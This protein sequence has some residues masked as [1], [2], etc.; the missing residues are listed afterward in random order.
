MKPSDIIIEVTEADFEQQVLAYSH[1]VPVVVD[2]WAEW[3][4]PCRVIGPILE[5]LAKEAAGSF[6]LAKLNVDQNSKLAMRYAVQSIPSVKTFK[7]GLVVSEFLGALPEQQIK[8][9]LREVIPNQADLL[10]EK[11]WSL[12]ALEKF[13]E[14][15]SVFR[16]VLEIEPSSA[17][18]ELGLVKNLLYQGRNQEALEILY[19]F[20][21]SREL[22][23]AEKLIP[24]TE[25]LVAQPAAPEIL[26]IDQDEAAYQTAI[27]LVKLG[28]IEAAM[29]GLLDV[30][31]SDKTFHE[32]EARQ[33]MIGLLELLG[34]QN[35][36]TRQY[37]NELASILF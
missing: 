10:L 19:Q 32:N 23:S 3:C 7:G 21:P 25:A 5:K 2:F 26:P 27:R 34:D 33:V 1:L 12:V 18:A 6:R 17:S 20:P 24:L 14:S 30:L 28:N 22:S 29:D 31:R 16:Q 8:D 36:L 37:R 15:E 4:A 35:P 9:Y 13:Q 11:A